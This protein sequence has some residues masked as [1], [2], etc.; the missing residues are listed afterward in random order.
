A[1]KRRVS[2]LPSSL[3]KRREHSG[4]LASGFSPETGQ[5]SPPDCGSTSRHSDSGKLRATSSSRKLLQSPW[6]QAEAK[7]RQRSPSIP[8]RSKRTRLHSGVGL[9]L[10]TSPAVGGKIRVFGRANPQAIPVAARIE[11]RAVRARSSRS[12]FLGALIDLLDDQNAWGRP[13]ICIA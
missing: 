12:R 10:A 7:G 13:F 2:A 3:P 6:T 1:C 4:S 9:S 11:T 8:L 5:P